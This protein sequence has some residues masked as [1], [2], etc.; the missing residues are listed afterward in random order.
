VLWLKHAIWPRIRRL[1][2]QAQLHVYGA[3]PPP[4]ALALHNAQQGFHVLGWADDAQAVMAQARVC[5]APLRYGAGLKGKLADALACGTPSVTTSIGCE[6]M[7]GDL[8]WAGA[9]ADTVED[10]AQASCDLYQD[11][12]RWQQAHQ[13]CEAIL[14]AQFC[15]ELHHA[16]ILKAIQEAI[17]HMHVRRLQN[18]TGSM[19]RHHLHKSTQYMS[20]WISLKNKV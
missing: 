10:F 5:L 7:S 17:E 20:Q 2:P 16:Q 19:L 1:L 8:A 14:Q 6:G 15:T 4:K 3:Y 13:Q 18:F 9:V 12:T 11:A